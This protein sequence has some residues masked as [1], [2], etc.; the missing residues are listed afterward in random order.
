M[1]VILCKPFKKGIIMIHKGGHFAMKKILVLCMA[2]LMS[3]GLCACGNS[4]SKEDIKESIKGKGYLI[5]VKLREDKNNYYD[6]DGKCY[7]DGKETDCRRIIKTNYESDSV[8]VTNSD[9]SINASIQN[10]KV[11]SIEFYNGDGTYGYDIK[12]KSKRVYLYMEGKSC[13]YYYEGSKDENACDESY[14][15]DADATK[16]RY[17]DFLKDIDLS[18]DEFVDF[19][20]EYAG[21]ELKTIR[22]TVKDKYMKQEDLTAYEIEDMLNEH[23]RARKSDDGS[24]MLFNKGEDESNFRVAYNQDDPS[25]IASISYYNELFSGELG[26]D[27]L[28]M[29]IYYPD[30]G[31]EVGVSH[32]ATCLYDL[33]AE[34]S[35]GK[36]SCTESQISTSEMLK[37]FFE[38]ELSQADLTLDDVILYFT[39]IAS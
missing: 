35:I 10:D 39:T 32:E 26:S 16:K 38:D 36:E 37:F 29:Y 15:K 33:V 14:K 22:K 24:Y 23:Y 34:E 20:N 18:E 17:D 8:Q 9:I 12:Q 13:N 28:F 21:D 4:K 30:S 19:L 27:D 3:I 5:N 6:E 25:K 11:S 31:K 2:A 1:I 7:A